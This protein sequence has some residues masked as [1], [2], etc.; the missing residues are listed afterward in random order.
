MALAMHLNTSSFGSLN[1]LTELILAIATSLYI[2]LWAS[3]DRTDSM[4]EVALM[5]RVDDVPEFSVYFHVRTVE[6]VAE[7]RVIILVIIIT[8]V[9]SNRRLERS[10]GEASVG[11]R[12]VVTHPWASYVFRKGL[13]LPGRV[14]FILPVI[15]VRRR[16]GWPL[17]V[18]ALA[19]TWFRRFRW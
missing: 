4:A 12:V 6:V 17:S 1:C 2:T 18:A 19:T 3:H 14:F 5:P 10:L 13:L 15:H 7:R 11:V 9:A 16:F 8:I